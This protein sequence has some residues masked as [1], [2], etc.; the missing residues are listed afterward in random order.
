MNEGQ[1]IMTISPRDLLVYLC[2]RRYYNRT[3]GKSVVTVETLHRQT[4]ACPVTV[5]KCLE[6]LRNQ[7]HISY[8]KKGRENIYTFNTQIDAK[9]Y[10]FLDEDMPLAQKESMAVEMALVG[11]P[12][13]NNSDKTT[14]KLYDYVVQLE[15]RVTTLSSHIRTL[16]DEVNKLKRDNSILLGKEYN[17]VKFT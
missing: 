16:T 8:I 2:L 12:V 1:M 9:S 5:L 15:E 17:P 3:T 13:D 7:G 6:N 14:N 11:E 4:A 10:A